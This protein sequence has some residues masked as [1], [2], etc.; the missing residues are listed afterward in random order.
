MKIFFDIR[1]IGFFD[2]LIVFFTMLGLSNA[3]YSKESNC[4]RNSITKHGWTMSPSGNEF[5]NGDIIG[6][7]KLIASYFFPWDKNTAVVYAGSRDADYHDY[8]V[9]PM[10]KTPGVGIRIKWG[11]YYSAYEF[12]HSYQMDIGWGLAWPEWRQMLK[13]KARGY[14]EY[15]INLY[16]DYEIVVIDKDKYKGG[17]LIITNEMH[18]TAVTTGVNENG[19]SY[20]CSGGEVELLAEISNDAIPE[21]P[22]PV[23]PTCASAEVNRTVKMN[24]VIV[25]QVSAYESNR[26][27][28]TAGEF[29]IELIGRR[30]PEGTT[31][32]A[33]FTD[34]KALSESNDY[35]KSSHPDVGVRLYHGQNQTPI[36]MGPA[37]VGATLP[38]RPA[39]VEGPVAASMADLYV[40]ITAQYVQ[41]PG[42]SPGNIR[43]GKMNAAATVTFMYD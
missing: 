15:T 41:M 35:L 21:L 13:G 10:S 34:T 30:C 12:T 8:A 18:V 5:N 19:Q 39:V 9:I 11:G 33:F 3:V 27:S 4:Q 20:S 25:S 43:A 23:I 1:K 17:K 26:S 16:Y 37:P 32:K 7:S 2:F 40:P 22:K 38:S 42:A 24:P 36:Q 31:I 29:N 14:G 6:R 28:G